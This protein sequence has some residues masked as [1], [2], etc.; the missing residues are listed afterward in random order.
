MP[1]RDKLFIQGAVH[2]TEYRI[3]NLSGAIVQ[4]GTVSDEP[5]HVEKIPA[6]FY[7]LDV[8]TRL[9]LQRRKIIKE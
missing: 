8:Q 6:G 3:R 9:G 2:G 4:Q 7:I 1:V 5:V